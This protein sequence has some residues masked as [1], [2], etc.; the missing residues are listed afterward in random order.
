MMETEMDGGD[1]EKPME[2]L[3]GTRV[4]QEHVWLILNA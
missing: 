3:V 1:D 4:V 2:F